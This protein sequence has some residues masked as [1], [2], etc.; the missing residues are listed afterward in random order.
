MIL[1]DAPS[2]KSTL[3]LDGPPVVATGLAILDTAGHQIDPDSCCIE[4]IPG[5]S[6][7]KQ[8][9]STR[10]SSAK[11]LHFF[12]VSD[13]NSDLKEVM[14]R[15]MTMEETLLPLPVKLSLDD[16]TDGDMDDRSCPLKSRGEASNLLDLKRRLE[17]EPLIGENMN[18]RNDKEDDQPL[19]QEDRNLEDANEIAKPTIQELVAK[20]YQSELRES[21]GSIKNIKH[22]SDKADKISALD[23]FE[24]E[25]IAPA[26][27]FVGAAEIEQAIPDSNLLTAETDEG[28][29]GHSATVATPYRPAPERQVS[30]ISNE[31]IDHSLHTFSPEKDALEEEENQPGAQSVAQSTTMTERSNKNHFGVEKYSGGME[32][33]NETICI[34]E[35]SISAEMEKIRAVLNMTNDNENEE[36]LLS[37]GGSPASDEDLINS[38]FEQNLRMD[39]GFLPDLDNRDRQAAGEKENEVDG[40]FDKFSDATRVS[41]MHQL[42]S[43]GRINPIIPEERDTGRIENISTTILGLQSPGSAKKGISSREPTCLKDDVEQEEDGIHLK[44]QFVLSVNDSNAIGRGVALLHEAENSVLSTVKVVDTAEEKRETRSAQTDSKYENPK[45]AAKEGVKS[46]SL[47]DFALEMQGGNKNETADV[48]CF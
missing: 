25:E 44:D 9:G 16:I 12:E 18:L 17:I 41:C 3:A 33:P 15:T 28:T 48:Q 37:G 46:V 2:S 23:L 43:G 19:V 38:S 10:P 31:V 27:I 14:D 36:A 11:G 1:E 5:K 35:T 20:D 8:K 13:V 29:S 22:T 26:E 32:I 7:E 6:I 21:I 42:S 30:G 45:D 24:G 39:G 47:T 40:N 34:D 4:E